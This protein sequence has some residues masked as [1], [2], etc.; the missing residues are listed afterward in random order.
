[1][2]NPPRAEADR[3]RRSTLD[4][5]LQPRVVLVAADQRPGQHH[6]KTAASSSGTARSSDTP[7]ARVDAK[8]SLGGGGDSMVSILALLVG[9]LGVLL[10][11]A[12]LLARRGERPLT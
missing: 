1:V 4:E 6:E 12:A 11:L 3:R 7:A 9:T 2:S 5:A 10:A 8:A